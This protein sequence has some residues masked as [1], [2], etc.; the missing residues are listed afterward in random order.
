[1]KCA[2][3]HN[4]K[5][6]ASK[7]RSRN[8]FSCFCYGGGKTAQKT[9]P[10]DPPLP[11]P[12]YEDNI[13]Q[14]PRSRARRLRPVSPIPCGPLREGA[15]SKFD[16]QHMLCSSEI[17]KK[18]DGTTGRFLLRTSAGRGEDTKRRYNNQPYIH[19]NTHLGR[20]LLRC[21]RDR[22]AVWVSHFHLPVSG[23]F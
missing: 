7:A 5:S 9:P 21:W 22:T 6:C 19:L 3:L 14:R 8:S 2:I 16:S 13:S 23:I 18:Y 12:K 11:E 17:P 15:G 1:M 20:V 4:M 10:A